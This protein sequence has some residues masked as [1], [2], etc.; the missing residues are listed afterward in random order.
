M[1]EFEKI[2]KMCT[3]LHERLWE[4]KKEKARIEN[5]LSRVNRETEETTRALETLEPL[6]NVSEI[7]NY[8]QSFDKTARE[9]E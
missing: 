7:F 2:P 8:I 4:L 5:E 9:E 6:R 1:S 3:K